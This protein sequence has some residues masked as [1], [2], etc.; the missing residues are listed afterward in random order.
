MSE[1][2]DLLAR[3]AEIAADYV[4]SLGERPV[5]PDVTPEQ[6]REALGGPLPNEPLPPEQVVE[7]LAAAAEPGVVA[8]G[9]GRYFGFVIGGALPAALAADWLTSAWDQNAGLY[10]GG[11]SASVV[12]QVT[13]EWLVDLLGLPAD[14]SAGFVTGTQMAHVTALAAAR[15]HVLDAVGWDVGAKGL[16]GAPPITVLVGAKAHVTV[17]R[18][19]RLLGLGAPTVVAA[20]SQGRLVP[21]ALREALADGPTIVCAQAGEVATGAFDPLP[22]I[23]DACEAAGAWLH[24]DG[25]F[26]IWAAVSPRLR[27]LVAGL[28]RADSWTTDAHKW[29][30]VPYDSGIALCKHPASHRAAM[31]VVASYLIQDEGARGVRDQVDWVPEFSRRA[32]GFAVYAALRSLGRSGLVELVER[33]CDAASRFA[34][35][36]AELDG[37]EVLNEVVLN[38]VLFRFE[39]DERTDEVLARVQESGRIW[40]SGTIWDG[41][42]A[43]RVSVSNWQTGDEEIDLAVQ[44]FADYAGKSP[45]R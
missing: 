27:H 35:Q 20:D 30:N 22:E 31:T 23:A 19:L 36:I 16:T 11:P 18:A 10:V 13:R 21:E 34:G 44:Q 40:L 5:F 43:I 32:R 28:E 4:E 25:A 37:V 24:V 42:K 8:L 6:L 45:A 17:D 29:L 12:E 41:R 39:S 15:W 9:S 2:R 26:G 38:Q 1:V 7:E 3:T 14:A 33:C